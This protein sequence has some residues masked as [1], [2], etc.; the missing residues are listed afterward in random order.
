LG[1]GEGKKKKEGEE[2]KIWNM[3]GS[4]DCL[5]LKYRRARF[6]KTLG[7]RTGYKNWRWGG[8]RRIRPCIPR[9]GTTC[10]YLLNEHGMKEEERRNGK[11][12]EKRK[13]KKKKGEDTK[14]LLAAATSLW[15]LSPVAYFEVLERRGR[16]WKRGERKEG[17]NSFAATKHYFWQKIRSNDGKKIGA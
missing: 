15:F 8:W 3:V 1:R 2:K 17:G 5:Y 12:G 13:R 6:R 7:E 4:S 10:A 14:F 16:R 9:R 11:G